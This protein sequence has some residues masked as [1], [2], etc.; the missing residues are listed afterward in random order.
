M[1]NLLQASS[2]S[3]SPF[4]HLAPSVS[5][6]VLIFNG[7]SFNCSIASCESQ[8]MWLCRKIIVFYHGTMLIMAISNYWSHFRLV[9]C[10]CASL[11]G[12]VS[13]VAE[14]L[15]AATWSCYQLPG[16]M[17]ITSVLIRMKPIVCCRVTWAHAL[18]LRLLRL[19]NE[20][21]QSFRSTSPPKS[22]EMHPAGSW[23]ALH[24]MTSNCAMMPYFKPSRPV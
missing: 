12:S 19:N 5:G 18:C 14:P 24:S 3:Y 20:S 16:V 15:M 17:Q 6:N 8:T 2:F 10:A 1:K 4:R 21:C 13:F 9:L 22:S 11:I 23:Q 7:I